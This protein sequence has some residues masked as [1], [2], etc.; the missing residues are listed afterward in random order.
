MTYLCDTFFFDSLSLVRTNICIFVEIRRYTRG[1]KCLY[2][3]AHL[4]KTST[5][6]ASW[7]H[8]PILWLFLDLVKAWWRHRLET[9]SA[10]LVLYQG[11][12]SVTGVFP[13][14]RP[15]ARSFYVFVDLRLNKRLS[16]Q[17]IC[18]LTNGWATNR[19][20]SYLRRHR[21]H[22][23]VTVMGISD[24]NYSGMDKVID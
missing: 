3:L 23:D 16:K 15:V 20:G 19:D 14:Q 12:P 10:L 22:Y 21:T 6:F 24:L 17:S 11:N 18:A 1:A 9:F 7:C 4:D 5:C 13:T 8:T 2:L